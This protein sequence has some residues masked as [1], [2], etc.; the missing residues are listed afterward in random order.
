[1]ILERDSQI[2]ALTRSLQKVSAS[3]GRIA[4]VYGEAGIGKSALV[5]AFLASGPPGVAACRGYCDPLR[6]PRPLGPIRD[7]AAALLGAE[8][9]PPSEARHFD[10]L[11][12]SAMQAPT[13]MVWIIED[14]HWADQK[15]LDWL[16]FFGRRLSQLPVLLIGTFRDDEAGATQ[17]LRNALGALPQ[18]RMIRLPLA[19]LSPGAVRVLCDS[20][21][22]DADKLHRVTGG[23]PFFV[24]EL[25]NAEAVQP[26]PGAVADV[27]HARLHRLPDPL[28]AFLALAACCPGELPVALLQGM[29]QDDVS[30][31]CDLA[32]ARHLL[33]PTTRGFQFRHEITRLAIYDRIP[34]GRRRQFHMRFLTALQVRLDGDQPLDLMVHHAAAA[35]D[36]ALLLDLAPRAARRAAQYGAH[37]EAAQH[38]RSALDHADAA[39]V[40]LAAEINE[41]W[42]YE[43]ALAV[44]IDD[45]VIAAREAAIALWRQV[46]R[47]DK[48]G[49]NLSWL[50]RMHWYRGEGDRAQALVHQAVATLEAEAPGATAA[51]ARALALRAQYHM[52]QDRMDEAEAWGGKALALARQADEDEMRCHAL[53]TIGTARLFRGDARGEAQLRDSLRI[54]RRHGFHEQA[55]RVYTNLS[56][57]L[58]EAGALARAEALIEEGIAFDS[59]NDLDSW[60]YYLVGRKAQLRFEQDRYDEA[61]LIAESAL[62]Q[63]RQTLLMQMPARIIL[64]RT[65]LRCADEDGMETLNAALEAAEKIAEPQYLASLQIARMEAALLTGDADLLTAAGDW[66]AALAPGLLSPRK[67]GEYLLWSRLASGVGAPETDLPAPFALFAAGDYE[68]AHAAFLLAGSRYLAAWSL[69]AMGTPDSLTMAIDQMEKI[70]ANAALAALRR[71]LPK[72]PGARPRHR[73]QA[74][75]HGYGLTRQERRILAMVADGLPNVSIAE[76]LCRSRRTVENHVSSILSKLHCRNRLEAVLR[77]QAEPWIL[78]ERGDAPEEK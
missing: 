28:R 51:R 5:E 66:L 14:L 1:M 72:R 56:E 57:C 47:G 26:V 68:R 15:S 25:M 31:L 38:W 9:G 30:Q 50:S 40:A 43:T 65:G 19:T 53:N 71:R 8:T 18:D 67:R 77:L 6:T 7:L 41:N 36:T 55:A 22:S 46:G 13:P 54:A 21:Q 35:G 29:V 73:A 63:P 49:E 3:G 52:L 74:S 62:A 45:A 12:E 42:A 11:V 2:G 17:T 37:R 44:G 24:T 23:N 10:R 61:R 4:L 69:A 58:I 39:P 32:C 20:S 27:I 60:T 33:A 78:P 75:R 34:L 76:E 59:S 48:V 70:G 64:A 16:Q